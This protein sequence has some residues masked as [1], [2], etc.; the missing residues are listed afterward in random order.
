METAQALFGLILSAVFVGGLSQ[1]MTGMGFAL[2]ASPFLVLMLGPV[3][4]VILVNTCSCLASTLV[5]ARVWRDV[6]W[7]R[8]RRLVLWALLGV[9]PGAWLG[10]VVPG[11]V[12]EIAI[13]IV[14]VVGVTASVAVTR[15]AGAVSSKRIA[16]TGFV[17][18]AMGVMAGVSGPPL[19]V[20][21][22]VTRWRHHGF[23]ATVQPY[24]IIVASASVA[25]SYI[26]QPFA[27]PQLLPGEWAGIVVVLLA[28]LLLG[29]RLA[30]IV[31]Q[32]SARAAMVILA[33]LGGAATMVKGV[34]SIS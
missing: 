15:T 25:V 30:S 26:S 31:P 23:V 2:I 28:G 4:G 34:L 16:L 32:H 1:R 17:S 9:I 10:V 6:E 12:L 11:Y 21:A 27:W 18:G 24:F 20:Y 22:V 33:V 29:D 14:V 19:S 7:W 8:F 3:T 5:V 13:G